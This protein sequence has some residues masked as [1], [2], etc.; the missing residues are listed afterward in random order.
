MGV[1]RAIWLLIVVVGSWAYV[2]MARGDEVVAPPPVKLTAQ[3]DH[4]RKME[5]L[6]IKALRR[7]VDGNNRQSP[8]Y[9]NTDEAKANPFPN[10]P[11]ALTFKDGSKVASAQDWRR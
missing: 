9:Q 1:P 8:N 4:A 5:Q 3:Q 10:L 6:G 7:G 2:G 11:E